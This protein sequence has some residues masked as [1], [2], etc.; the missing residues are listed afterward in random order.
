MTSDWS[1]QKIAEDVVAVVGV[2]LAVIAL[3]FG[4]GGSSNKSNDPNYGRPEDFP[5][6]G[7]PPPPGSVPNPG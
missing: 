4:G 3:P 7:D 6:G 2:V 1:P 5:P